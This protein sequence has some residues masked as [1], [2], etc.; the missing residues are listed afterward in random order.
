[1]ALEVNSGDQHTSSIVLFYEGAG[2]ENLESSG[3]GFDISIGR[4]L[5]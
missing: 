5:C 3:T 4:W 1:M 2:H